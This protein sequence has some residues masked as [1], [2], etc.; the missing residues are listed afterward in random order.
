L[1][2][3]SNLQEQSSKFNASWTPQNWGPYVISI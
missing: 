1:D 2:M 3:I